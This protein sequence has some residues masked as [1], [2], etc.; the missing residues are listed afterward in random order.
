MI[1]R[2]PIDDEKE[3]FFS[4]L[5]KFVRFVITVII[6]VILILLVLGVIVGLIILRKYLYEWWEDKNRWIL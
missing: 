1:R 5:K 4:P 3:L 2:S 6:N